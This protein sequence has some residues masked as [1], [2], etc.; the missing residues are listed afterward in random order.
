MGFGDFYFS[1]LVT[2]TC[3][4]WLFVWELLWLIWETNKG[5][6]IEMKRAEQLAKTRQ[7]ILK[8]ATTLFLQKGF[9]GASTRD[10]A[11]QIGI[12]Q[13]ALYHHFNNKEVLY[14]AVL[15]NLCGKVRQD[16][17]K[18][19]R[20]QQ[21]AP[22]ERLYGITEVLKKHHPLNVYDQYQEAK[23]ELSES[24]QRKLD[25]LFTMDYIEPIADFFK[26]PEVNL[27]PELL[28]REAAELF[29]ADLAPIFD[30]FRPIGGHAI[31]E[32][33]RTK[34]I[35]DCILRGLTVAEP[36]SEK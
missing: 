34:L 32:E 33:Q 9:S 15:T 26:L 29:L 6:F 18:V 36:A 17:N 25:M 23:R 14:L 22:E 13:P 2:Q 24:A 10:I 28:P 7:A 1:E 5:E 11:K 19:M 31:S 20:K 12:T 8:T 16:I 27:R 4:N 35:L 21:I 3:K 30:S